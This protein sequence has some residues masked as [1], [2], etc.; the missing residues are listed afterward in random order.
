MSPIVEFGFQNLTLKIRSN[1]I[2]LLPLI[3][4][5]AYIILKTTQRS[6]HTHHLISPYFPPTKTQN[7][8][9]GQSKF[10]RLEEESTCVQ[11]VGK[12][13]LMEY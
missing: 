4:K 3:F 5:R 9:K 12:T 1:L 8:W 6:H 13:T 7:T 10:N 2:L 11:R